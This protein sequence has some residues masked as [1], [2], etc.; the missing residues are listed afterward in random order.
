MD[1]GFSRNISQLMH[2]FNVNRN[3]L[4]ISPKVAELSHSVESLKVR[5]GHNI[6]LALEREGKLDALVQQGDDLVDDA[7]VFKKRSTQ[8]QNSMIKLDKH[9]TVL[10]AALGILFLYII[11]ATFCGFRLNQCGKS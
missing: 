1:K 2:D 8:L 3:S 7:R 5:M 6:R 11:G 9:A 4:G 10:L